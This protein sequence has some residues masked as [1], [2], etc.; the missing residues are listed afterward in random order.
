MVKRVFKLGDRVR[1]N[2]GPFAA[3]TGRI[4]GINQSKALLN[5]MVDIFGRLSPVK[6]SFADA[7][8]LEFDRPQ[9]PG[10]SSN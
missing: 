9:P 7:E 4:E 3:F 5:V 8:K 1:I 6:I 10:F 2:S